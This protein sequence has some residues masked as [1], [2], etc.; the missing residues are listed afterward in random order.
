MATHATE[1]LST[2]FP[3]KSALAS[4]CALFDAWKAGFPGSEYTNFAFGKDGAYVRPLVDGKKFV[5]RHVHLAPVA[6]V[7]DLKT[8]KKRYD[9]GVKN[10]TG[11]RRTSNRVL[12]YVS[13]QLPG[14]VEDHLLMFILNEPDA[15]EI[16]EM[17]TEGNKAFMEQFSQCAA[18]FLFD[19]TISW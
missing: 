8:W 10:G 13:R 19:G 14:G 9:I 5:L 15:H 12:I 1:P 7:E 18:D 16:A 2:Q 4:F 6:D 17:K 11:S 3:S